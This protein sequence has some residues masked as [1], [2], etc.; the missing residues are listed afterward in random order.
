MTETEIRHARF[1]DW[2]YEFQH[3]NPGRRANITDFLHDEELDRE[4]RDVWW[5]S[6][7]QLSSE[8]LIY[9]DGSFVLKGASF[10]ITPAGRADVEARRVRLADCSL[11]RA[12]A[13]DAVVKWL[14]DQPGHKSQSLQGMMK[15]PVSFYEGEP[16]ELSDLDEA[17]EYLV[18]R[19]LVKGVR[20]WA[21]TIAR[22]ELTDKGFHCAE[23]FG[24]SVSAYV[25]SQTSSSVQHNVNFNGPV[26]GNVAWA[27]T[28]VTQTATGG[29]TATD[30]A[31]MLRT[32]SKAI[33]ELGLGPEDTAELTN[34]LQAVEG[35][36]VADQPDTSKVRAYLRRAGAVLGR[37]TESSLTVVFTAFA[38]YLMKRL[39]IPVE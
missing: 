19:G 9:L 31:D 13:R 15:E 4:A 5:S 35:E 11:R 26:S 22:P 29:M 20:T 2:L 14:Y 24:S 6:L 33:P 37:A 27:S 34:Q 39:G 32:L 38:E 30:L 18:E 3:Q 36:L 23:L 28:S 16:F 12:S 1:L 8:G 7:R 17:V 21:G 25:R 10:M